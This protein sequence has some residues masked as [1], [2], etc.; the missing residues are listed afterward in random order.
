M[1]SPVQTL[2]DPEAWVSIIKSK[3]DQEM[4]IWELLKCTD[5]WT[6]RT[7]SAC[8]SNSG[9]ATGN[10]AQENKPDLQQ[11]EGSN[12]LGRLM[13]MVCSVP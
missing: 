4:P 1:L 10:E 9:D 8:T 7:R 6:A 12:K 2:H 5:A 3:C 13:P 11:L